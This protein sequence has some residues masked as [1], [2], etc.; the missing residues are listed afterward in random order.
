MVA[1]RTFSSLATSLVAHLGRV[2][3]LHAARASTPSRGSRRR[4]RTR[5]RSALRHLVLDAQIQALLVERDLLD[6]GRD[7]VVP[8]LIMEKSM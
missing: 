6:R 3:R 2:A 1:G 7:Q 5:G 8:W 4:L